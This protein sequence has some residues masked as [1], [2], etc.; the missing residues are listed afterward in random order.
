MALLA[1]GEAR[2]SSTTD[3]VNKGHDQTAQP[4]SAAPVTGGHLDTPREMEA[5]FEEIER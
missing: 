3:H 1:T 2:M 4:S 5:S